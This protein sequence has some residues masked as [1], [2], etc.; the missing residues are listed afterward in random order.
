MVAVILF[1]WRPYNC[2]QGISRNTIFNFYWSCAVE[3]LSVTPRSEN[4]GT[5]QRKTSETIHGGN[6]SVFSAK[7]LFLGA[8]VNLKSRRSKTKSNWE[9][10]RDIQ[11]FFSFKRIVVCNTKRLVVRRGRVAKEIN[12]FHDHL[13]EEYVKRVIQ[14]CH[15][16]TNAMQLVNSACMNF[17]FEHLKSFHASWGLIVWRGLAMHPVSRKP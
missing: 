12:H 6:T 14:W 15:Q 5:A 7:A 3:P 16:W 11:V 17:L 10:R 9:G 8:D 4:K 13:D 1:P 2:S